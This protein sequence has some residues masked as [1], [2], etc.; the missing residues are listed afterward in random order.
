[1]VMILRPRPGPVRP[2]SAAWLPVV[3][4]AATGLDD[5]GPP[6]VASE[7]AQPLP[8]RHPRLVEVGEEVSNVIERA[9]HGRQPTPNTQR[10]AATRGSPE[11]S[12]TERGGAASKGSSTRFGGSAPG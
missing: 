6:S 5:P 9:G 8:G 3:A 10:A 4:T 7:L 2:P 11:A 1:M 12:V